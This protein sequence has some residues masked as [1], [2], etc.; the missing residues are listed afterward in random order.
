MLH[1]TGQAKA[2]AGR[3]VSQEGRP[4]KARPPLTPAPAAGG[5]VSADD[6][7]HKLSP[8]KEARFRAFEER[9]RKVRELADSDPGV[10]SQL[11]QVW[12]AQ[13]RSEGGGDVADPKDESR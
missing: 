4:G 8:D 3:A 13:D 6:Y 12:F 5:P 2:L 10:V 7:L 1:K 11:L 9:I